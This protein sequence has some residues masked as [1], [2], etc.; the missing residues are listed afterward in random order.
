M[1][2]N[3]I[4]QAALRCSGSRDAAILIVR[5]TSSG[6]LAM[7]LMVSLNL[8]LLVALGV[9]VV[10]DGPKCVRVQVQMISSN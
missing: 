6:N 5:T 1:E 9:H 7:M 3:E 2:L 4:D 10:W 8:L